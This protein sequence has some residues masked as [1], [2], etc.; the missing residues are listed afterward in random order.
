MKKKSGDPRK[1][2][3]M[4]V[5]EQAIKSE[6]ARRMALLVSRESELKAETLR[7]VELFEEQFPESPG[8]LY[9][10]QLYMKIMGIIVLHRA[11]CELNDEPEKYCPFGQLDTL[12]PLPE[13]RKEIEAFLISNRLDKAETWSVFDQ[14]T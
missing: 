6:K 4:K 11:G 14:R 1:R 3:A 8:F 9:D 2:H 7:L 10:E 12:G 5:A 13:M